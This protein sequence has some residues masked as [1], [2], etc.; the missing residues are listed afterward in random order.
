MLS[1]DLLCGQGVSVVIS[2]DLL[3]HLLDLASTY[4]VCKHKL[5]FTN[6]INQNI[7]TPRGVYAS[8]AGHGGRD[9]V[10]VVRWWL[11]AEKK[12]DGL[13]QFAVFRMV[14]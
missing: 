12:L 3:A 5:F 10:V 14:C 6:F 9:G 11:R 2:A 1:V 13:S 7:R 8:C 4:F